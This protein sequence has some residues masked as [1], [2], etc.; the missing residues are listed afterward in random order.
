MIPIVKVAALGCLKF[1]GLLYDYLASL[2]QIQVLHPSEK[3]D[4]PAVDSTKQ[5]VDQVLIISPKARV[6]MAR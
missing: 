3:M 1:P 4:S 6:T 2:L 5:S